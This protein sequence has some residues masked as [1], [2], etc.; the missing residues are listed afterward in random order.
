MI[1]YLD[2]VLNCDL[3]SFLPTHIPLTQNRIVLEKKFRYYI[4]LSVN[5]STYIAKKVTIPF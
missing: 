1:R 2:L 4:F 5:I 3:A